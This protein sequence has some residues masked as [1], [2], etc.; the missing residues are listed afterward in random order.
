M[1]ACDH[2]ETFEGI[3]VEC[4]VLIEE[5]I[6][7]SDK[8]LSVQ[9]KNILSKIDLP[10]CIKEHIEHR[11]AEVRELYNKGIRNDKVNSFCLLYT[12]YAECGFGAFTFKFFNDKI[13]LKRK[14]INKAIDRMSNFSLKEQKIIENNGTMFIAH[15]VVYIKQICVL[16]KVSEISHLRKLT[17]KIVKENDQLLS[18]RPQ[19][20]AMGIVKKYMDLK[21]K[22]RKFEK[23]E[24]IPE[25]TL[26]IHLG[27]VA[28]HVY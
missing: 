10:K 14:E 26:K 12:A 25:N 18:G 11:Y 2:E 7:D 8:A 23:I 19:Y 22:G 13:K 1:D 6:V 17:L 3:C 5:E 16:N 28:N 21:Y 9:K 24:K 4:G 15:P 27:Y 20:I